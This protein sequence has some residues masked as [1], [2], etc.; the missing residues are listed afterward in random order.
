MPHFRNVNSGQIVTHEDDVLVAKF[1]SWSRW[2]ETDQAP[3]KTAAEKKAEAAAKKKADAEAK[4]K[5]EA[6]SKAAE[7]V[8]DGDN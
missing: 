5:A 7:A 8:T 3:G 6:A 2:E 4:K 1:R